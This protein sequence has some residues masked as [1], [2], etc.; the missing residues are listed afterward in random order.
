M[1]PTLGLHTSIQTIKTEIWY[2]ALL[3]MI[4][5]YSNSFTCSRLDVIWD[6]EPSPHTL[7]LKC[8]LV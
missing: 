3:I 8:T 6:Q 4:G 1:L 7:G 2:F 5:V